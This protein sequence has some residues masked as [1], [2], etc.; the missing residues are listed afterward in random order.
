MIYKTAPGEKTPQEYIQAQIA[1][2]EKFKWFMGE[3]LGHD[4][5]KDRTLNEIYCE[6]IDKYGAEFRAWWERQ[7]RGQQQPPLTYKAKYFLIRMIQDIRR[8]H[9]KD[10]S[11]K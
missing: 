6:W 3:K 8:F 4:P 5:L 11:E 2:M 10:P 9:F 7:K 1:E